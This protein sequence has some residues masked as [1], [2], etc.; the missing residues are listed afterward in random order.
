M[1][2]LFQNI[3]FSKEFLVCSGCFELFTKIKKGS[4][5]SF[6]C[7]FSAWFFHENVPLLILYQLTMFQC[8]TFLPSQDIKR[9]KLLSY[10]LD[11]LWLRKLQY[12]SS[13]ILESNDLLGRKVGKMK[14]QKI[15]YLE[16]KKNFSDEIKSIFHNYLRA[17]IWW[18]SEK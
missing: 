15:E 13:I 8:H 5:T 11:N 12:I 6:W 16:N 18:K 9:N 14:M 3:L 10:Y 4:G 7:T 1:I 2:I 17:I